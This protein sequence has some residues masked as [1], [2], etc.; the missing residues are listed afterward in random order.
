VLFLS[1]IFCKHEEKL[2]FFG[3]VSGYTCLILILIIARTESSTATWACNT[4]LGLPNDEIEI[5][6]SVS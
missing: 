6:S 4:Q 1:L 3:S 5:L 2:M